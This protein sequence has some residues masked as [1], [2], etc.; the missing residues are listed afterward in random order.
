[1]CLVMSGSKLLSIFTL[2]LV[3]MVVY[4]SP[5]QKSAPGIEIL[6]AG[7]FDTIARAFGLNTRGSTRTTRPSSTSSSGL[8]LLGSALG[9]IHKE[10]EL[11][12]K[13]SDHCWILV[14]S[15]ESKKRNEVVRSAREEKSRDFKNPSAEQQNGMQMFA[16]A[17]SKPCCKNPKNLFCFVCGLYILSHHKRSIMTRPLLEA[18]EAHFKVRTSKENYLQGPPSVCN[19]CNNALLRWKNGMC[20]KPELPFSIPMLWSPPTDHES[21]CYFCLTRTTPSIEKKSSKLTQAAT[22]I[23]YPILKSAIRPKLFTT[24]PTPVAIQLPP[25]RTYSMP[26]V[27]VKEKD[28]SAAMLVRSYPA[29][30]KLQNP[31]SVAPVVRRSLPVQKI[32]PSGQ[33]NPSIVSTSTLKRKIDSDLCVTYGVTKVRLRNSE[34]TI[35]LEKCKKLLPS[36]PSAIIGRPTT[37]TSQNA[38]RILNVFSLNKDAANCETN[39]PATTAEKMPQQPTVKIEAVDDEEK[40][41]S[42]KLIKIQPINGKLLKVEPMQQETSVPEPTVPKQFSDVKMIKV[43]PGTSSPQEQKVKQIVPAKFSF[44]NVKDLTSA[45]NGERTFKITPSLIAKQSTDIAAASKAAAPPTAKQINKTTAEAEKKPQQV[46]PSRYCFINMKDLPSS[47]ASNNEKFIKITSPIIGQ[48]STEATDQSTTLN[49][50][51]AATVPPSSKVTPDQDDIPHRITQSELILLLR[52]LEL[53]KEK[54]AVLIDRLKRWNLLAVEMVGTNRVRS[55]DPT[56][57]STQPLIPIIS[58][59]PKSASPPPTPTTQ[60]Q[61]QQSQSESAAS[62]TNVKTIQIR[63]TRAANRQSAPPVIIS[64]A[65]NRNKTKQDNGEKSDSQ[66]VTVKTEPTWQQRRH[67]PVDAADKETTTTQPQRGKVTTR[68]AANAISNAKQNVTTRR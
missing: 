54:S 2:S 66:V 25:N 5:V 63:S 59:S 15:G 47:S 23:E 52:E 58:V 29:Q 49:V 41:V 4:G 11:P 51:A 3:G 46:T 55:L 65:M 32:V 62:V 37:P 21:D 10:P 36:N 56:T 40:T 17:I 64:N 16:P 7:F 44:I 50:T 57:T 60:P 31:A 9:K 43:E 45:S 19:V 33:T 8:G 26:S 18:Y 12:G 6:P 39:E 67:I 42:P 28:N 61:G 13:D 68:S 38:P 30:I 22:P 53:P 24:R 14:H 34:P 48:Q 20:P 35:V 27:A 1:M